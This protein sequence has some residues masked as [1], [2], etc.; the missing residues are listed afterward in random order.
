LLFGVLEWEIFGDIKFE[1]R[2]ATFFYW[3]F[4]FDVEIFVAHP[5]FEF[6]VV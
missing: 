5:R 3:M 2:V 4:G 6:I 1:V